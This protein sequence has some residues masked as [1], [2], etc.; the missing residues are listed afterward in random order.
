MTKP[1]QNRPCVL[2]G[3]DIELKQIKYCR[4]CAAYL[5]TMSTGKRKKVVA[6]AKEAHGRQNTNQEYVSPHS[7]PVMTCKCGAG[8]FNV[9][10][11]LQDLKNWT[12]ARCGERAKR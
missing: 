2:C 3:K 6:D 11:Y 12:C 5:H 10:P 8:I 4:K 9:P 1:K 7:Q